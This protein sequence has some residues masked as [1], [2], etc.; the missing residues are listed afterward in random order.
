MTVFLDRVD[1]APL[2]NTNFT[3]EYM[4]WV[5]VLVDSLNEVLEEIQDNLNLNTSQSYT[6]A[7]ITA[8]NAAGLPDGVILYDTDTNVYVGKENGTL[9]QFDTSPYP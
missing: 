5:S 8:L 7:Q 4:Q 9:V 1:A 6:A 3:F 2:S